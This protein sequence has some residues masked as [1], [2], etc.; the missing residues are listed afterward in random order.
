MSIEVVA[1]AET[2][3]MKKKNRD[4]H[5]KRLQKFSKFNEQQIITK[6]SKALT[7]DREQLP[8]NLISK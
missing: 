6:K 2:T 3:Q 1:L 8:L 7:K 4:H 5:N